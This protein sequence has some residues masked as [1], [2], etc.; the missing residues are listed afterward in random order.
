MEERIKGHS[1]ASPGALIRQN[2]LTSAFLSIM[3]MNGHDL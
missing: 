1:H 2:R 3:I